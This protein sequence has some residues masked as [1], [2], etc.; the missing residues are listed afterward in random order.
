M[1]K[2]LVLFSMYL[3]YLSSSDIFFIKYN[4]LN[5]LIYFFSFSTKF[6]SF[7]WLSSFLFT[8]LALELS[9]IKKLQHKLFLLFLSKDCL[10]S[11]FSNFSSAFLLS[12]WCFI[13]WN[14]TPFE[15][16][17]NFTHLNFSSFLMKLQISLSITN[18]SFSV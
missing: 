6:S 17:S 3:E 15:I 18:F 10:N 13:F 8:N 11:L 2:L 7:I 1:K 12:N 5:G 4:I 9:F 14:R 16:F